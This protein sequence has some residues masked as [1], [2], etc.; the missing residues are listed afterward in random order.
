M[1]ICGPEQNRDPLY[2]GEIYVL[3]VLPEY[4]HQGIGR[5]LVSACVHHLIHQLKVDTML[6]WV[7]AENPYRRFYELLG[8]KVVREKT[9]EIGGRMLSEVGYG[10]ET[11]HQLLSFKSSGRN[12]L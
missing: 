11:I 2:R 7:L 1:A 3:Y 8:G 4:Q 10:W 12:P 6:I 5:E 9:Q